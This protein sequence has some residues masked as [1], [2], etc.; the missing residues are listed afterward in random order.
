MSEIDPGIHHNKL[1]GIKCP[2]CKNNLEYGYI[3]GDRWG[4]CWSNIDDK[5]TFVWGRGEK[6]ES[7]DELWSAPRL[8]G[9]R[10]RNCGIIL[11]IETWK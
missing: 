2:L 6:L 3:V 4:M 8:P 5:H 11:M 10:C 1:M 7:I 9:G